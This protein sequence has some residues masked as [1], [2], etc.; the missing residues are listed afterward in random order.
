MAHKNYEC[1]DKEN[2]VILPTDEAVAF[3]NHL[4]FRTGICQKKI[5]KKT[6][7]GKTR[8]E[9]VANT[10][11]QDDSTTIIDKNISKTK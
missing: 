11:M 4:D 9:C 5:Q 7:R 3:L 10:S 8:D 1:G 6:A 2:H